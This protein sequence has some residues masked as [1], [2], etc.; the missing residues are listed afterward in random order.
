MALPLRKR[1][2]QRGFD[3]E[4]YLEVRTDLTQMSKARNSKAIG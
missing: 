3:V 4:L 1:T 2:E